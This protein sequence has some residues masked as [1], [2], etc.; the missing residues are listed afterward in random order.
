MKN[1]SIISLA[2]AAAC[3]V[4]PAFAERVTIREALNEVRGMDL[5][6]GSI[7]RGTAVFQSTQD[8]VRVND[9]PDY[10]VDTEVSPARVSD[11]RSYDSSVN[12]NCPM[13]ST[14]NGGQ[15][16]PSNVSADCI[17]LSLNPGSGF[18]PAIVRTDAVDGGTENIDTVTTVTKT[19]TVR[20]GV[21]NLE[22]SVT[23]T[24]R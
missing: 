6:S 4:T 15:V 16:Y 18:T 10:T 19:I 24:D 2:L 20:H 17:P 14:M 13:I 1:L 11:P 9:L 7:I 21:L 22:T 8:G 23:T 12:T 3:L 5:V